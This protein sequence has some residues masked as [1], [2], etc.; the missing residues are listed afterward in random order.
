M[1]FYLVITLLT[2]VTSDSVFRSLN[3]VNGAIQS[4]ALTYT[5]G[6]D[7]DVRQDNPGFDYNQPDESSP[8]LAELHINDFENSVGNQLKQEMQPLLSLIQSQMDEISNLKS[9]TKGK[10][11]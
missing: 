5:F 7:M 9:T 6:Q 3:P 8:Y 2:A 10:D 11:D 1:K 4:E